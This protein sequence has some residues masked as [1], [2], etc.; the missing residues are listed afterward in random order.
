VNQIGTLWQFSYAAPTVTAV[1]SR[2]GPVVG[3]LRLTVFGSGFGSYNGW[4]S[5]AERARAFFSCRPGRAYSPSR[6]RRTLDFNKYALLE[7]MD[8]NLIPKSVEDSVRT[9]PCLTS[10]QFY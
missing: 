10:L 5:G 1:T 4:C 3:G 8:L 2:L 9:M 7:F 6:P